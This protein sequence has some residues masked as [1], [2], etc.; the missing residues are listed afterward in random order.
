LAT[1][2]PLLTA[3]ASVTARVRRGLVA[4]SGM[5]ADL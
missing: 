4:E 2:A 1:A 5:A 3:I